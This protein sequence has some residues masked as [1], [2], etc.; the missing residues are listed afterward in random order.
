MDYIR[1]IYK[2]ED[3]INNAAKFIL[4]VALIKT[5]SY[6]FQNHS[7]FAKQKSTP[8]HVVSLSRIG[9]GT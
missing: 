2:P 8:V 6:F 9:G 5:V 3:I 1:N 4:C 7:P